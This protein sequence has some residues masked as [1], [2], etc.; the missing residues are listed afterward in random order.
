MLIIFI[1]THNFIEVRFFSSTLNPF[2]FHHSFFFPIQKYFMQGKN[3]HL[4]TNLILLFHFRPKQA[5]QQF[6]FTIFFNFRGNFFFALPTIYFRKKK[7]AYQQ[8]YFIIFYFRGKK[9]YPFSH[10]QSLTWP[11]RYSNFQLLNLES[12]FYLDL[13]LCCHVPF[14]PTWT[15]ERLTSRVFDKTKRN[16]N[17]LVPFLVHG[18]M[19]D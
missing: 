6:Y 19:K 10:T 17:F 16:R 12:G 2:Q 15:N 7:K 5:Y 11:N 4:S 14:F 1:Q 9:S 18:P 3:T 13:F 8:F